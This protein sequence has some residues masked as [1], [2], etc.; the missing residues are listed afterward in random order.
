MYSLSQGPS[1]ES[2]QVESFKSFWGEQC[3]LRRFQ[4][5]SFHEAVLWGT[6]NLSQAQRR[7]IPEKICKDVLRRHFGVKE[8]NVLCVAKQTERI[9]HWPEYK[10]AYE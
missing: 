9:L 8:E 5:G 1:A 6:P 7:L 10:M 4:D 3:S 2:S